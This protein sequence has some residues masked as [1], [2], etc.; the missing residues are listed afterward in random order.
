MYKIGIDL[1]VI[2]FAEANLSEKDK[3]APFLKD[4]EI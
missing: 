3:K 4:A 2:N 1:G